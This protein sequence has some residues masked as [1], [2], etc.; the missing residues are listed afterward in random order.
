MKLHGKGEEGE[1][2]DGRGRTDMLTNVKRTRGVN[3]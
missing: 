2:E 1:V 3:K